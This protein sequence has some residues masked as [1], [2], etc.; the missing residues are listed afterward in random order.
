MVAFD[1]MG[2]K[3]HKAITIEDMEKVISPVM[4]HLWLWQP[5]STWLVSSQS[6]SI[7]HNTLSRTG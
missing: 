7:S 2:V 5:H 1:D 4:L 3:R 6:L